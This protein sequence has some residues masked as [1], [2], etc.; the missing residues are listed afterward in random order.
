MPIKQSLLIPLFL[1][2]T[3]INNAT[4]TLIVRVFVWTLAFSYL[5]C[6]PRNGILDAMLILH[7]IFWGAAKLFSTETAPFYILT[8]HVWG[9]QFLHVLASFFFFFFIAIL[10][11]VK[12]YV[13]QRVF[14]KHFGLK[15][16]W[17]FHP[18]V[19][20]P[21]AFCS[22]CLQGHKNSWRVCDIYHVLGAVLSSSLATAQF[23]S[24]E[25]RDFISNPN[26]YA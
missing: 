1:N 16:V 21:S 4:C 5:G 10:V 20:S 11:G 17:Q 9:F 7:L 25:A 12:W 24:A 8:N 26:S 13:S 2:P 19:H 15:D 6:V 22:R 18:L 23:Q 3:I 14:K